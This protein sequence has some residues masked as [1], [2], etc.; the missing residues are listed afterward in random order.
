MMH[1]AHAGAGVLGEAGEALAAG[2]L[3]QLQKAARLDLADTL[4]GDAVALGDLV[5]R[6]RLAVLEAEAQLDHLALARGQRAEHLGDALLEERLIDVLAR[7][8]DAAVVDELAQGALGLVAHR[9]VQTDRL[10]GDGPQRARLLGGRAED[11]GDV[12]DG[13][14]AAG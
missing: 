3:A 10:A 13:G 9:L 8:D 7:V 2:G 12:L 14:L 6:P 1:S 4:A 5:E 11:G